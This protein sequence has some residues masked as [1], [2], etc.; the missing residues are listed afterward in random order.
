M[1]MDPSIGN[2]VGNVVIEG[3]TLVAVRPDATAGAD[4][5]DIDVTGSIVMPGF[6]DAN[7]AALLPI[8][9]WTTTP[10]S[11]TSGSPLTTARTTCKSGILLPRSNA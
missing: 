5:I 8:S 1:T 4:A 7:S 2:L 10:F 11:F 6:V 3:D 9:L